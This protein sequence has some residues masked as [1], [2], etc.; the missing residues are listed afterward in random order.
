M[1]LIKEKEELL[2]QKRILES[3]KKRITKGIDKKMNSLDKKCGHSL[4]FMYYY[5]ENN[6]VKYFPRVYC[7]RCG[8]VLVLKPIYKEFTNIIDVSKIVSKFMTSY[9]DENSKLSY[10]DG[11]IEYIIKSKNIANYKELE[12]VCKSI[13]NNINNNIDNIN[14]YKEFDNYLKRSL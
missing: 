11:I 2:K 4:L 9:I 12:R 5:E 14:S 3:K 8:K 13:F 6:N 10:I 1:D 7:Y